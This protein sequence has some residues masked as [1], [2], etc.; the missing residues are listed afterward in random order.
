M[1][2]VVYNKK[3]GDTLEQGTGDKSLVLEPYTSYEAPFTWGREWKQIRLGV[4]WSWVSA[5]G[6]NT[7]DDT[8]YNTPISPSGNT[9]G[10]IEYNDGDG[11]QNVATSGVSRF[12]YGG[13]LAETNSL[14]GVSKG[15]QTSTGV[16]GNIEKSGFLG[17]K[18]SSVLMSTGT[19]FFDIHK[20]NLFGDLS[21]NIYGEPLVRPRLEWI[22]GDYRIEK[23]ISAVGGLKTIQNNTVGVDIAPRV[24]AQK[25]TNP[26]GISPEGEENFASFWG[27]DIKKG[28]KSYY[29]N[30]YNT[31]SVHP[32]YFNYSTSNQFSGS[33]GTD[34][35]P[36]PNVAGGGNFQFASG[37]RI[38]NPSE[39]KI[40]NIVNGAGL[41]SGAY[42]GNQ[43]TLI[44]ILTDNDNYR[45]GTNNFSTYPFGKW[46]INDPNTP[47]MVNHHPDS[48][49]FYNGFA[50]FNIRIHS[51]AVIKIS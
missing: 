21:N 33:F 31:Y 7:N 28:T 51:W 17:W 4:I 39:E 23:I 44:P 35:R 37:C 18:G 5:T 42:V 48:V 20:S 9:N 8:K 19:G 10:Y 16:P 32:L 45:V 26:S 36:D 1:N 50:D 25:N 34:W 14:F 27:L 30:R 43:A 29:E 2:G 11:N 6:E 40:L 38:S 49:Y 46:D 3:I 22:K 41:Q 47:F 13:A 12:D 24:Y 15:G